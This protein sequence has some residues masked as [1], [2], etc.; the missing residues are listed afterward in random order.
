[1]YCQ[2][3]FL[4]LA[5]H[6]LFFWLGQDAFF[7]S[8]FSQSLLASEAPCKGYM[9]DNKEIQGTHHFVIPQDPTSIC[10]L[11]CSSFRAF[12]CFLLYDAQEF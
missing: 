5:T 12:L 6:F 1:M 7:W 10:S 11:L 9:G 8:F 2:K 3:A 4:F